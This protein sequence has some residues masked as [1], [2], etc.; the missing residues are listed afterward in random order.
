MA[1]DA[2]DSPPL[3]RQLAQREAHEH[4]QTLVRG[5][6]DHRIPSFTA[7]LTPCKKPGE[8]GHVLGTINRR[9]T[10]TAVDHRT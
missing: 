10:V 8:L 7:C 5:P 9:R 1:A 3:L 2:R 6:D 4:P